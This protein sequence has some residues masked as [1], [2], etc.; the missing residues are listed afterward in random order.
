[1]D[2]PDWELVRQLVDVIRPYA[3]GGEDPDFWSIEASDS[4]GSYSETEIDALKAAVERRGEAPTSIEIR[5]RGWEK[6]TGAFRQLEVAMR[7]EYASRATLTSGDEAIVAHVSE[8]T[9]ALL[10]QAAAR[11][12]M[13]RAS[14]PAQPAISQ[15]ASTAPV[16]RS[17]PPRHRWAH[18]PNPW[19]LIIAGTAA[20]TI[21]AAI[22]VAII[23]AAWPHLH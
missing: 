23:F 22:V 9:V 6:D 1:V 17:R 4:R 8:R 7:T 21:I 16:L 20:A 14:G 2:V 3:R 5:V 18:N 12:E 11:R 19:I 10:N 15:P 13:N